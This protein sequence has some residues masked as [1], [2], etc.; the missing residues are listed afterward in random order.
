MCAQIRRFWK[1]L[2]FGISIFA[3][4]GLYQAVWAARP[5]YFRI[6]ADVNFLPLDLVEAGRAYWTYTGAQ[7]LPELYKPQQESA[8]EKIK[9]MYRSAQTASVQATEKKRQLDFA[10]EQ[11]GR[12]Y[13]AFE[14]SQW[15]QVEEYVASK[16]SPYKAEAEKLSQQLQMILD[17]AGV[18]SRDELPTGD[19]AVAYAQLAIVQAT[20]ALNAAKAEYEARDYSL[21]HLTEFQQT[22]AQQAWIAK[23]NENEQL[24]NDVRKA[25]DAILTMRG[26]FYEAMEKYRLEAQNTLT[27]WDFLYFSVGAATTATF[28]DIAP[29]HKLVRLMVCAQ[30]IFSVVILGLTVNQIAGKP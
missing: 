21:R 12:D 14:Q 1:P 13:K 24:R 20:A 25:Q 11:E 9:S 4:A 15:D 26:G 27:Y 22:P 6:S 19:I 16:V 29:N 10:L 3:M 7:P 28:G 2:A 5:D 23:N 18:K 30:V 17:R 8:V